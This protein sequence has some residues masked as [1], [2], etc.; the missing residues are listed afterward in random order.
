MQ[1]RHNKC[2][3]YL[4]TIDVKTVIAQELTQTLTNQKKNM[5]MA[6]N[7]TSLPGTASGLTCLAITHSLSTPIGGGHTTYGVETDREHHYLVRPLFNWPLART[8]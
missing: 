3:N 2:F 4:P 1:F 7:F 5:Q 8:L 6:Q